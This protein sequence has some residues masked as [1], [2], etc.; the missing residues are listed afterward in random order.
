M[1]HLHLANV[2]NPSLALHS[3]LSNKTSMKTLRINILIIAGTLFSFL[4]NPANTNAQD[5][6]KGHK[7]VF[8]LTDNDVKSHKALTGQL[9]NLVAG[10]PDAQIEVVVH[11]AGISYLQKEVTKFKMDLEALTKNGVVFVACENTL[12]SQN[13]DKSEILEVAGFVPMGIGEVVLKQEAGWSY[14]KA[15]F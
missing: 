1:L 14:I 13:I 11:S 5:T 3:D 2:V 4:V 15:G 7:I 6:G 10:W 8:Q 9:K 12:R